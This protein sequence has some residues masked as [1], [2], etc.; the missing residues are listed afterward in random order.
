MFFETA[1]YVRTEDNSSSNKNS[2]AARYKLPSKYSGEA[3][4]GVMA[5][6]SFISMR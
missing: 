3:H 1:E 4:L 6:I 5:E 2:A